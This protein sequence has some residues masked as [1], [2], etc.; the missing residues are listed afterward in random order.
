[1]PPCFLRAKLLGVAFEYLA[2]QMRAFSVVPFLCLVFLSPYHFL[3]FNETRMTIKC[4]YTYIHT[5]ILCYPS[6]GNIHFSGIKSCHFYEK[7][8]IMTELD[9]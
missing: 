1:M 4:A 3:L 5:Y 6:L 2:A 9:T 8:S 7:C